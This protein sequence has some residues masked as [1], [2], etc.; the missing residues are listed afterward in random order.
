M[1]LIEIEK[2]IRNYPSN[3]QIIINAKERELQR[4]GVCSIFDLDLDTSFYCENEKNNSGFESY[5]EAVNT[6]ESDIKE[7]ITEKL[8]KVKELFKKDY[9]VTFVV[10]KELVNSIANTYMIFAKVIWE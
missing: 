3:M 2:E 9:E 7:E 1:R 4:Q 5:E 8:E 10:D 6:L